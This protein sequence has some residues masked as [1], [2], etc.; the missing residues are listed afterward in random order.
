MKRA[1]SNYRPFFVRHLSKIRI[2]MIPGLALLDV[3]FNYDYNYDLH[4]NI[5]RILHRSEKPFT[6]Q[7]L[8][9]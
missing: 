3:W 1:V 6:K 9:V 5:L 8:R 7:R 2:S 4:L